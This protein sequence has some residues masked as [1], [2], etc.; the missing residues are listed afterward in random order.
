MSK[1]LGADPAQWL[2]RIL[3]WLMD[4]TG[5]QSTGWLNEL[6]PILGG[7]I[8]QIVRISPECP[9]QHEPRSAAG[10]QAYE[11]RIQT[12]HSRAEN[13]SV[14]GWGFRRED[15]TVAP[16]EPTPQCMVTISGCFPQR[17]DCPITCYRSMSR[18]VI[19]G[20]EVPTM[21]FSCISVRVTGMHL[22]RQWAS[23]A[24][25]EVWSVSQGCRRLP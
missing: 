13:R 9:L 20:T 10:R 16:P 24:I 7:R 17:R 11:R 1:C 8:Q 19:H 4:G 25:A 6:H 18:P 23:R 15:V 3:C 21:L 2:S 12:G 14:T 5:G 22:A